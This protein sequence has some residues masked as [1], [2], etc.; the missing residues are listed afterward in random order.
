MNHKALSRVE[1]EAKYDRLLQASRD[2]V[3][4]TLSQIQ[5]AE[6]AWEKAAKRENMES[7]RADYTALE[8]S[9]NAVESA[10]YDCVYLAEMGQ[11]HMRE[12]LHEQDANI[13]ARAE[14]DQHIKN[15][16]SKLDAYETEKANIKNQLSQI[17]EAIVFTEKDD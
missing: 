16:Y 12:L 11:N 5:A 6:R 13:A 1:A 8:R 2:G 17:V 4:V 9:L 14:L 7:L 15:N 10:Q 3:D